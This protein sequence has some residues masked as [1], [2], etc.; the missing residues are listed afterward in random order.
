MPP[1]MLAVAEKCIHGGLDRQG[2]GRSHGRASPEMRPGSH[3]DDWA[4]TPQAAPQSL[5]K[6]PLRYA[7]VAWS[8]QKSINDLVRISHKSSGGSSRRDAGPD[9]RMASAQMASAQMAR[10]TKQSAARLD[11]LQEPAG[12]RGGRGVC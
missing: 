11:V 12:Y 2:R 8:S 9:I 3:H 7:L 1:W 6:T 10:P 5:K 4:A